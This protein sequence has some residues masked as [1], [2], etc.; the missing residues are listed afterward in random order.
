MS[1]GPQLKQARE[2]K[3]I[4]L[5]EA[6]ARTK[7]QAK[8]LE[9]LEND[10][11]VY[12]PSSLYA[13]GF[14]KTYAQ[15][16][17]LDQDALVS[18]L[19]NSGLAAEKQVIILENKELPPVRHNKSYFKK[20]IFIIISACVIAG[21]ILF[22]I[23]L[24][25]RKQPQP[26]KKPVIVKTQ[27]KSD[28]KQQPKPQPQAVIVKPQSVLAQPVPAAD[29]PFN[30]TAIAKRPCYLSIKADGKLLFEGF[31]LTGAVDQW[32]AKKSF[33]VN[34]SDSSAVELVVN[35]K[36]LTQA[37]KGQGRDIVITKDGIR[38]R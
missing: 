30:L 38:Q 15:F 24:A 13:K 32:Q 37:A 14:L 9:A 11:F 36:K 1:I 29:I 5:Q 35:G 3:G 31:L 22:F 33:D 17:N 4:S 28:K 27:R 10:D 18:Q 23:S 34:I 7:I 12:L 21:L 26:K 2:S 19:E 6:S 25:G 20:A 16:L 8:F